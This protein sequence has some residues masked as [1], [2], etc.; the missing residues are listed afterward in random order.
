MEIKR[1]DASQFLLPNEKVELKAERKKDRSSLVQLVIC[2]LFLLIVLSG[3]CF[4]I[5]IVI[6]AMQEVFADKG[7]NTELLPL[8]IILA[9]VHLVPFVFWFVLTMQKKTKNDSKWYVLT[10]KRL[11]I[12]TSTKTLEVVSVWFNQITSLKV[13]KKAGKK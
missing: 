4:F 12:V 11:C 8:S 3:D 2:Y 6:N 10:N 5:T 13:D 1:L 7:V 9:V